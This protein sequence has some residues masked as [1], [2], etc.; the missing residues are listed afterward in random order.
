MQEFNPASS[1]W[2]FG[3]DEHRCMGRIRGDPKP[4][5]RVGNFLAM[6]EQPDRD[7]KRREIPRGDTDGALRRVDPRDSVIEASSV[8]DWRLEFWDNVPI[9]GAERVEKADGVSRSRT[10]RN[11]VTSLG[12]G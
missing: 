4:Q 1:E 9:S 2:D 10:T 7:P 6:V 3:F 12:A 11:A 8:K 5:V